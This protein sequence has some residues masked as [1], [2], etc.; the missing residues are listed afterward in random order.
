MDFGGGREEGIHDADGFAKA[1][2][3]AR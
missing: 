1:G 3:P 2:T